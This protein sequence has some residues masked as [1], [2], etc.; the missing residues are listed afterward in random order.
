MRAGPRRP[1]LSGST[2]IL[3]TSMT[4]WALSTDGGAHAVA[5]AREPSL[6]SVRAL[7]NVVR[8]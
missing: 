3:M 2:Q 1:Q 7:V 8:S 5:E 6:K 4:F